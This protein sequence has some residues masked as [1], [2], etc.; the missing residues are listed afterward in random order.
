MWTPRFARSSSAATSLC[1]QTTLRF[2]GLPK[3]SFSF[4]SRKPIR[5][6]LKM[7]VYVLKYFTKPLFQSC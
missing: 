6:R 1:F 7:S 3:A 4:F 2:G 5:I